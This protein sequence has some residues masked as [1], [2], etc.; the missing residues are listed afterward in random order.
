MAFDANNFMSTSF[1]GSNSTERIRV[2]EGTWPAVV[3]DLSVRKVVIDGSDRWVME[4]TWTTTSSEVSAV[5]KRDKS[6]VRQSCWLDFTPDGSALDMSEG[7]N[8]DLG[9][10]R[11]SL[12]QNDS[13]RPW[14]PSELKGAS[15]NIVVVHKSSK[16]EIYANVKEVKAF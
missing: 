3:T 13:S 8:V 12:G 11:E 2:P 5:T 14:S 16:G 9:I 4:V 1:R 6:T 10:L 15:A 7:M